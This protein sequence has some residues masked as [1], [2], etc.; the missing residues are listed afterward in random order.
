MKKQT[1]LKNKKGSVSNDL[2]WI[3]LLIAGAVFV[4]LMAI[5]ILWKIL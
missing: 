3:L 4:S 5:L 1:K 2:V